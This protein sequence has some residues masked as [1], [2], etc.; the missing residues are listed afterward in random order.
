[1][2]VLRTDAELIVASLESPEEFGVIYDR[3]CVAIHA[4]LARRVARDSDALLGDVFRVAFERRASYRPDRP[5]ALPWLYGIAWNVIARE[6]RRGARH[7]RAL[8]RAAG[9]RETTAHE[10]EQSDARLDAVGA[11]SALAAAIAALPDVER[12]ALLLLAWEELSYEAI[13]EA[14]GVPVGTVRSRLSRARRRVRELL[15][16]DGE[17]PV[18]CTREQRGSAS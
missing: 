6:R 2:P 12:E 3:H 13:A 15:P 8:V 14:V 4:Y 17:R 16:R 18:M 7:G 5:D 11:R 10:L 9:I 1:V